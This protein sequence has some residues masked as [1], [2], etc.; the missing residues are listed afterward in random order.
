[1]LEVLVDIV[2][3]DAVDVYGNLYS[4]VGAIGAVRYAELPAARDDQQGQMIGL[5][6]RWSGIRGAGDVNDGTLWRNLRVVEIIVGIRYAD[7]KCSSGRQAS[8]RDLVNNQKF[9][10]RDIDG[11]LKYF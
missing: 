10:G 2:H 11:T 7:D 3:E 8:D 5:H 4:R 6:V 9:T 1:M